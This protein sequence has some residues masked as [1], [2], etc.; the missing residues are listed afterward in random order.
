MFIDIIIV[1]SVIIVIAAYFII[2]STKN[3]KENNG[4]CTNCS[5]KNC[6]KRKTIK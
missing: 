1:F 5:V 3:L 2:K 4:K 6:S